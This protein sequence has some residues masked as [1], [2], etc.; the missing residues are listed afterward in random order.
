[1]I[2]NS[3]YNENVSKILHYLENTI[4]TKSYRIFPNDRSKIKYFMTTQTVALPKNIDIIMDEVLRYEVNQNP[5]IDI[6]NISPHKQIALIQNDITQIKADIIVNAA[7]TYGLGCFDYDHKCIDNIIHNKAGPSLRL[8][9]QSILKNA[10][11]STSDLI[12]TKGYNLPCSY[13][14]HTVGPIYD[15]SNKNVCEQQLAKCY[16][17]CLNTAHMNGWNSIVFCCI[18]T[19]V[20]G[21]PPLRAA[22]IAIANV[23]QYI[24]YSGSNIRVVFC[25]FTDNDTLIYQRLLGQ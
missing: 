22:E 24:K 17:S 13:I 15:E 1:M 7:N 6:N 12:I 19:G 18:S 2:N 23:R 11:I 20:Y 5:I 14:I 4:T 10:K 8:E 3:R 16:K 21:F 9:C 25:T